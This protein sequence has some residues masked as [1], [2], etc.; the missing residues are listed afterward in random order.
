LNGPE[1]TPPSPS[2]AAPLPAERPSLFALAT[3]FARVGLSSV[4]GGNSSWMRR[5]LVERRHWLAQDEFLAGF[6]MSQMLPGATTVNLAV[7]CGTKLRGAR[8]ACAACGGIVL[9]PML[10]I[11]LLAVA[12]ATYGKN[13]VVQHVLAGVSAAA[14]GLTLQMGL[15]SARRGFGHWLDWMLTAAIVVLVGWLRWPILHAMAA[16]A[17]ASILIAYLRAER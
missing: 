15:S 5:E 2:A 9:P 4:G 10:L 14:V 8:G 11:L 17:P 1:R 7:F 13:P 3:A 6:A 12:Y 16:I